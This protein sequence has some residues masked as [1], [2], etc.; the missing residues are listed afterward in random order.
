MPDLR[1]DAWTTFCTWAMYFVTEASTPTYVN[2]VNVDWTW[3]KA[4]VCYA[5]QRGAN[6]GSHGLLMK[7]V[8]RDHCNVRTE[9]DF[10]I[11][12]CG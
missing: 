3:D 6:G 2:Q 5:M 7:V 1:P 4:K 10:K 9:I 8:D 11:F 12:T